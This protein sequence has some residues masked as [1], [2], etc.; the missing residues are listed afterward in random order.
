MFEEKPP[1]LIL[2]STGETVTLRCK[3][4]G[5]P[6]PDVRWEQDGTILTHGSGI[7]TLEVG[8]VTGN[9]TYVCVVISSLGHL[10][11]VTDVV[12]EVLNEIRNLLYISV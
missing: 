2:V 5:A 1:R 9:S 12:L 6:I 3:A 11:A 10:E 8:P 7:S 4:R